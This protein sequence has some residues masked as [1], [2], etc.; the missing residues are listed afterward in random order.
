MAAWIEEDEADM[1]QLR[2]RPGGC[3]SAQVRA[4]SRVTVFAN[5]VHFIE[6]P[7][8]QAAD[9][10]AHTECAGRI[11]DFFHQL[12]GNHEAGTD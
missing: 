5:A 10:L 9:A 2:E 7:P 4:R 1:Q 11:I 8:L 6:R 12:V 3:F